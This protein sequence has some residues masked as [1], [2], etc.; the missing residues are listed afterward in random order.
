V[1]LYFRFLWLLLT[2]RF[3]SR[4]DSLG[5]CATPFRVMLTDL[6]VLMHVNNG[7]YLS[8][9]DLGR[10]DMMAR[11]GLM[12]MVRARGWY[13]VVLAQTIQY[14]RSLTL[15][16]RF[17]IV[18]R[19]LA[20]DDKAILIEQQFVRRGEVVATAL[21]RALFLSKNGKVPISELLVLVGNPTMPDTVPEYARSWNLAVTQW[22]GGPQ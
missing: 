19:V 9:M 17:E 7:V 6:D 4:V 8:M 12:P 22:Q 1:N 2:S 3:R 14:R 13:P 18:T 5:P 15:F 20:W 16:Q 21:V 11:S 10:I